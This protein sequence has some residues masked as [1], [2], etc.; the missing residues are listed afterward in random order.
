MNR[1]AQTVEH[2]ERSKGD[3]GLRR[4]LAARLDTTLK[5][6][7]V[8]SARVARW[9]DVSESDVSFWR[10]GITVPPMLAFKRIAA[11]LNVD[12]HWLCTGHTFAFAG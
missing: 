5:R 2:L 10:R 4:A 8:S 11:S 3:S 1:Y 6:A 9:L 12:M 7:G